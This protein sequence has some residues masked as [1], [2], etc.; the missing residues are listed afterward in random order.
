MIEARGTKTIK[1]MKQKGRT[2]TTE[3]MKGQLSPAT[4]IYHVS[5][6]TVAIGFVLG[7]WLGLKA[8]ADMPILCSVSYK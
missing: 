1:M 5:D 7:H 4:G 8:A 2:K 6:S 3:A